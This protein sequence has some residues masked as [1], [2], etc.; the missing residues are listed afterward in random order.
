MKQPVTITAVHL[1]VSY[2][3]DQLMGRAE[4]SVEID[5]KWVKIVTERFDPTGFH[6]SH[7]VEGHGI[8]D[9]VKNHGGVTGVT[10]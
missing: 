5:S 10:V 1:D 2:T 3:T 4:V 9:R 7:I 8:I 6:V